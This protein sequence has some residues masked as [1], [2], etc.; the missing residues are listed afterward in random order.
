MPSASAVHRA[1]TRTKRASQHV[2]HRLQ[3]LEKTPLVEVASEPVE[4]LDRTR[5]D[6]SSRQLD[7]EEDELL[8]SSLIQRL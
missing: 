6:F 8:L 4:L 2:F 1:G 5:Y 7:C 3:N